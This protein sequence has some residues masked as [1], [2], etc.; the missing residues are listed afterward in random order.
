M[1]ADPVLILYVC[2]RENVYY[3][4][5]YFILISL[6]FSGG[7]MVHSGASVSMRA[8]TEIAEAKPKATEVLA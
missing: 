2:V 3:S 7:K 6:C 5:I 8:T 4:D 1:V